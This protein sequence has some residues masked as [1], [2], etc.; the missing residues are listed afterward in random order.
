MTSL[1]IIGVSFDRG[2]DECTP[3]WRYYMNIKC[4][5][6]HAIIS[7]RLANFFLE[8]CLGTSL[9]GDLKD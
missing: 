1:F 6:Y 7:Y 9:K 5:Y 8:A 2:C 3:G 4:P